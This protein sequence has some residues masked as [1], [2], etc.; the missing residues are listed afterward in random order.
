MKLE[1]GQPAPDFNLLDQDGRQVS[2]SSYRGRKVLV[3]FYPK[4][5]T[6]GCTKEACQFNDSLPGFEEAGADILGISADD[7]QSH[8][9]FRAKYGLRFLLLTDPGHEVAKAYVAYGERML[10]GK[11]VT[12]ILRSTFLIDAEGGIAR[13]WYD[14]QADGHAGKVL[15]G[16]GA[17]R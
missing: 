16:L 14:V 15:E 2:L 9:A 17:S 11:P 6:P 12:G 4:D 5:D 10:Y 8:R 1:P 13:A 3:Y 7:A